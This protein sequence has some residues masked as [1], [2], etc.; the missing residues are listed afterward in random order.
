MGNSVLFIDD[1]EFSKLTDKI[2]L[3]FLGTMIKLLPE[4]TIPL[5]IKKSVAKQN[6]KLKGAF[7][8]FLDYKLS[9]KGLILP[10]IMALPSIKNLQPFPLKYPLSA[11]NNH[12]AAIQI[13]SALKTLH[14]TAVIE[15]NNTLQNMR[16]KPVQ[17]ALN[18]V[19]AFRDEIINSKKIYIEWR[20]FIR[21]EKVKIWQD[22]F[23]ESDSKKQHQKQWQDLVQ[24]AKQLNSVTNFQIIN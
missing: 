1:L 13:E 15:C 20:Y 19:K 3:E 2:G 5:Q 16:G 7:Q 9:F 4:S 6:F 23:G 14:K 22:D 11:T 12:D 10:S 21:Q 17:T 18:R 24:R 8:E